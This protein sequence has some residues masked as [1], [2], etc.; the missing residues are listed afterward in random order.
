M[1]SV[2]PNG[3]PPA[4]LCSP[5]L[6]PLHSMISVLP[7]GGTPPKTPRKTEPVAL[8]DISATEWRHLRV[9]HN[10]HMQPVALDDISATEWRVFCV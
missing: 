7:N 6:Q 3:G 8:D 5:A 10:A 2:L 1:I 4:E 9:A